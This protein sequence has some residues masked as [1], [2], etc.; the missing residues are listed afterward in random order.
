[1]SHLLIAAIAVIG[2]TQDSAVSL[3]ASSLK[4]LRA[5]RI[6]HMKKAAGEYHLFLGTDA[7]TEL[8]LRPE[9]VY[10]WTWQLRDIPDGA[11]FIWSSDDRPEAA[12]Q[13]F[14]QT[15][16]SRRW[17]HSFSSLSEQPLRADHNGKTV[18]SPTTAGVTMRPIP[19]A[20]TPAAN[21]IVRRRQMRSLVDSFDASI[22]LGGKGSTY[23]LR[24]VPTPMIR[25]GDSEES[26]KDGAIFT[27]SEGTNPKLLL[28]LESRGPL[29]GAWHYAIAPVTIHQA[30]AS[31]DK[32]EVFSAPLRWPPNN[33]EATMFN[34]SFPAGINE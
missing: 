29:N 26:I 23:Q 17:I 33:P 20:P 28:L 1:M 14:L 7:D 32:M 5:D 15:K 34:R 8:A 16:P 21:P 24:E 11:T 13:I 19:G 6:A 3:E 30:Q 4:Q 12:L 10:R 25:Y 9:P 31:L 18:W 2:Q 27:L 22:E